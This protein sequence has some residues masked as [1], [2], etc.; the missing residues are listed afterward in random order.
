M[1]YSVNPQI[2][3]DSITAYLRAQYPGMSFIE[4]GLP[5]DDNDAITYGDEGLNT[6][7]LLWYSNIKP[8]RKKSFAGHKLDSY[9]ATVDVSVIARSGTRARRVLNDITDRLI[10]FQTDEGGKLSQGAPLFADS[11]QVK[12]EANR[13]ERWMRTTRFD[14]GVASKK[15]PTPPEP[16]TP[17]PGTP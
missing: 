13:P 6:F 5:G 9:Y 17:E 7:V 1:D 12:Q 3:Q 8:G 4:D 16:E 2:E 15:T 11:R 14:F 10:G